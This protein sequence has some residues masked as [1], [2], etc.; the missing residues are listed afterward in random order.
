M[1]LLH[2]RVV[3]GLSWDNGAGYVHVFCKGDTTPGVFLRLSVSGIG[4]VLG[5]CTFC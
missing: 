3:R 2:V 4:V 5:W 1:C